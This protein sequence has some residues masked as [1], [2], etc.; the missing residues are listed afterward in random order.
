VATH[1]AASM[2]PPPNKRKPWRV[3]GPGEHWEDRPSENKAY[4]LVRSLLP[5]LGEGE[6]VTVYVYE[7]G[8][9]VL[10]EILPD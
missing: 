3:F 1:N 5:G 8:H 10:F 9:W 4:E 2:P 6:T 7:H